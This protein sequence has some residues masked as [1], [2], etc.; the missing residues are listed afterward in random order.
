M[1]TEQWNWTQRPLK[2]LARVLIVD[3]YRGAAVATAECLSLDG[4]QT[5][6]AGSCAEALEIVRHWVPDVILLDLMMPQRDGF[7]TARAIRES[8]AASGAF[9]CAYT[10]KHDAFITRS[11]DSAL[12][13]GYFRKGASP[14]R[15]V[16]FLRHLSFCDSKAAEAH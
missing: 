3:D 13:D 1:V 10:A 16:A 14:D 4:I 15:L 9:I 11:P 6:V 5:R 2:H 12:F 7:D 8:A